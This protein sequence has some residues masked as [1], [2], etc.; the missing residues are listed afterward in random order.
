MKDPKNWNDFIDTETKKDYFDSIKKTL[1]SDNSSGNNIYPLPKNFFRA[2]EICPYDKVKVVILGQ[3][4][5]HTPGT[6]NGL[7]FSV[8]NNQKLPPSLKNIF[9][10]IF[11]DLGIKNDKGDLSKWAHQGVLLLNSSLSVIE[12]KAGSHSKIGWQIFTD[13]AVRVIQNKKNIIFM[14]WGN[15]AKQKKELISNGNFILEAAHPSPFSANSGFFGCKHFSKANN[16]LISL[17]L[18]PIDWSLE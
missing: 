12:G 3:D 8:S 14:L 10:E 11:N 16:K 9:K 18:D 1:I 2:F 6:A 5:Y 13:R 4:P 17:G 7:A 15:Y